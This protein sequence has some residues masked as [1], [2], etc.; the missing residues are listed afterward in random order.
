MKLLASF[1]Q[2][3]FP[4]LA[5]MILA[6][7]ALPVESA[8]STVLTPDDF[9]QTVAKGVWFIEHFS[10]YCG[11]CRKFAPTWEKLVEDNHNAADPGI[12]LA[13]VN[14]AVHG[15]LC[16]K[17]NVDGYPQMNL[18]RN[19]E[20]IE[21]YKQSREYELLKTYLSA[22]AEPNSVSSLLPSPTP[23]PQSSIVQSAPEGVLS[24]SRDINPSG[25]VLALDEKT[26]KGTIDQ[27]GVFVKFFAPW[28]GH[29]KKLAPIWT[30]LAGQMQHK[31]T[32]AEVNCEEHGSL[33]RNEG[34]SGYPML[35]YYGGNR[36]G[37]TEYTGGR[38]LGQLKA[39]ADK[40]SGPAVQELNY[41]DFP[42]EVVDHLVI[43]LLLHPSSE[44]RIVNEVTEASHVLF[45]APSLYTSSS[46][47]FYEHFSVPLASSVLL[48]FKDHNADTPAASFIFSDTRRG[49]D[50]LVK[51]LLSNRLPTS[52]ELDSDTFQEVMNAPHKPLAVIVAAP[53]EQK[54]AIAKE[55]RDIG[56]RWRNSKGSP[57]VVFTW[58]DAE[59]WSSWLKGMYGIKSD[60]LP[61]IVIANH[62][63]LVYYDVD[64]FGE[65]IQ[66][67]PTSIFSAVIGA[68]QETIPSKHSENIV[69]RL[70]RYLNNKLVLLESSV[71]SHPWLTGFFVVTL[72]VVIL[73]VFTRLIADNSTESSYAGN[74]PRK[75][76]RID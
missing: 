40:L 20:Y 62:S 75:L 9:D 31:L 49:R 29:C 66:L 55:V 56:G 21:T 71:G 46:P 76:R 45:G 50:A 14:C 74:S 35:F 7:T 52:M 65:R 53:S 67:T 58:M 23:S 54:D 3:P 37:K 26:F 27:G 4:L 70:A 57:S 10:P 64:Q 48:A 28:C 8:Q 36:A 2:L 19:G 60:A 69:E 51:W 17:H 6:V 18:Y 24:M 43:Y 1:V 34:V 47:S 59:K 15:D 22:H 5:S 63:R 38:G 73:W 25:S 61:R 30:Q 44:S 16:V 41:D 32:I 72:L 11:H 68:L 12:H 33:C 13:Q 39:F 42:T